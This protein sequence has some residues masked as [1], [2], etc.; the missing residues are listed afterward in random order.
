MDDKEARKKRNESIL[1]RVFRG[2]SIALYSV[3]DT[4]WPTRPVIKKDKNALNFSTGG[5]DDRKGKDNSTRR[6]SVVAT[7]N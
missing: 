7:N 1:K 6:L 5:C 4:W 2:E 3:Q